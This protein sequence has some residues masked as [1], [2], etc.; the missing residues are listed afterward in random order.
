MRFTFT[1]AAANTLLNGKIDVDLTISNED[2]DWFVSHDSS[3]W[4]WKCIQNL[5]VR[6]NSLNQDL[7]SRCILQVPMATLEERPSKRKPQRWRH[8]KAWARHNAREDWYS[9]ARMQQHTS[10]FTDCAAASMDLFD[11]WETFY[12]FLGWVADPVV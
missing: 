10:S 7:R 12:H 2:I 4:L 1:R 6:R 9:R 11:F 3:A 5:V 8:K